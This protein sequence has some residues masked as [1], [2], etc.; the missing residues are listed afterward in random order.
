MKVLLPG[1]MTLR[2]TFSRRLTLSLGLFW[3]IAI[4]LVLLL[5][6]HHVASLN[7]S[8]MVDALAHLSKDLGD[9]D[10][11]WNKAADREATTIEWLGLLDARQIERDARL[12]AFFTAQESTA[13]FSGVVLKQA[14]DGKVVFEYWAQPKPANLAAAS[15]QDPLWF[16]S[17]SG[18]LYS[19]YVKALHGTAQAFTLTLYRT[20][21]HGTLAAVGDPGGTK[22]LL[23]DQ[24]PLLSSAGPL[25]LSSLH[26]SAEEY[27]EYSERGTGYHQMG[28]TFKN[29][30]ADGGQ[31]R[32]V[33]FVL[34]ETN[35][36]T[37]PVGLVVALSLGLLA[38][39]GATLFITMGRWLGSVGGRINALTYAVVRFQQDPRGHLSKDIQ[40]FLQKAKG[41][42]HDQF[43]IVVH[44]I[45]AL[46]AT[47]QRRDEEQKAY[48]E[49]LEL[50]QDAVIEFTPEEGRIQ[51]ATPAW[52][53]MTGRNGMGLCNIIDVVLAQDQSG[54]LDQLA[55]L[56]EGNQ[57]HVSH[58]FRLNT[59]MD[60][61]SGLGG[62]A[63]RWFEGRFAW[64]NSAQNGPCIRAIVR[65][66]TSHFQQEQRI[67]HLALHDALT[68]LP[69]RTLL[70]D[71]F[72][73]AI[74]YA[75][76]Q[77][78][79]LGV[80]LID[81]DGFKAINDNFGHHRGDLL[82]QEVTRRLACIVRGENTLARLGGDE[83]AVIMGNVSGLHELQNTAQCI[84]A[85]IAEAY[86]IDGQELHIT[87]SI[88]VT[89]FPFDDA[90]AD[91]LLRHADQAMYQAKQLGRNRYCWFDVVLDQATESNLRVVERT[92][93]ALKA[94][95]LCLYYQ[96]KVNMR[97]GAVEGFEALLRWQH[98]QDGLIPPLNFLPQVEQSELI[99]DIGEWVLEQA[100]MQIERWHEQGAVWP[101]SVNIAARHFQHKDFMQRLRDI[102]AR[103]PTVST[104]LL[105]IEILESVA[106]GDID[107]VCSV[108][109]ECQQLGVSF[110]LDDFG[111]G[112]SSLSYLKALRADTLKIDQS[113]VRQ[114]LDDRDD[115]TLVETVI[116]IARL[117][118][119]EVI[120]EGVESADH[121]I[122]LLRMGCDLAQGYGIAR[123]MPA[124]ETF[125]W[126]R[127]YQPAPQWRQ[128][129]N[130]E[131]DW[132][133][134]PLVMAQKDHEAW[135]RQVLLAIEGVPL[136]IPQAQFLDPHQC[137]FGRW[138][139]G[140]GLARY[141]HLIEFREIS[142]VH[143]QVHQV[144]PAII[145]L[146]QS[147]NQEQARLLSATLLDLQQQIL[148][149]LDALQASV[150]RTMVN[151]DQPVD[152]LVISRVLDH[153]A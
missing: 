89:W 132:S 100:L 145:R 4:V 76:Q 57:V 124:A 120:A 102:L 115:L 83:F 1:V 146:H 110:S 15:G 122:L 142:A 91:T 40:H 112:Y 126:A 12:Q 87:S 125:Q 104:S 60:L 43:E 97:S 23:L 144:G 111:T 93:E 78:L 140:P 119:I 31:L 84:L 147:G 20:W 71:R 18:V 131:W 25:G 130:V 11:A 37:V 108:I 105:N 74:A 118:K 103:H 7:R 134:L 49:T 95:E 73:M 133:D 113:F 70:T 44:E 149:R 47:A 128:W 81:L 153:V 21:D 80:L 94:G 123:P 136:T 26:S 75:R 8:E 148:L 30:A 62:S 19:H 77:Q 152:R 52:F 90:D 61:N 88:G 66:I 127:R 29:F 16:D 72:E 22:F 36:Y 101:V 32:P 14:A 41:K 10:S 6:R 82:L 96:P 38:L 139:D 69:N 55:L 137:R 92:R 27:V 2:Q 13:S 116:N 67:N 135:I 106:L 59:N 46:M 65:D 17:A 151:T 48:L 51:R 141:G 3:V 98:P 50:L 99:I 34:Q 85:T 35:E 150:R 143:A 45:I 129:A 63:P 54:L 28:F 5:Y 58:R 79:Q 64:F 56:Q 24:T 9:L 121:G 53:H 109:R 138:Y 114:M 117:F 39:V 86:L 107:A 33:R 42:V 68:D